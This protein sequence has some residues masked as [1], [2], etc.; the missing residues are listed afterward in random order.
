MECPELYQGYFIPEY[1]LP[2]TLLGADSNTKKELEPLIAGN[3]I[4]K[5]VHE[6]ITYANMRQSQDNLWNFL[7]FTGYLKATD[8]RFQS[9]T[10][11]LILKFQTGKFNIFIIIQYLNGS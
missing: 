10:I 5:P 7:F 11:W 4:E 6:N 1:H 8:Q 9:D 2:K 3:S